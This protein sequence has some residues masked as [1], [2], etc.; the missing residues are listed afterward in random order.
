[1]GRGERIWV[2][3]GTGL[4]GSAIVRRLQREPDVTVL[5]RPRQELDLFDSEAV[6]SF[7]EENRPDT[8]ILAAAK[9]GGIGANMAQPV[10]FLT[11]NLAIQNNVMTSAVAGGVSTIM[12][13]GS[14][15]IYPREC[16]QPMREQDYMTGALEPTNESYAVAKIAGMR[17]AQALHA[18]HGTRILLPLPCNVYGQGDHFDPQNSHVLSALVVKFETAC[19]TYQPSVTLWGTGSAFREFIHCDDLADAC[20]FLLDLD[21]DMGLVNVGTGT[22]QSIAELAA[23]VAS[24]VGFTGTIGWDTTKPD[25]MPRKVLD[26]SRLTAEGWRPTVDLADGIDSVIAEYRSLFPEEGE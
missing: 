25:G 11:E 8:V 14:S 12:F 22:D 13:L 2:A 16:A 9:V 17:L 4:V 1:V 3:G 19:R 20:L 26:V 18:E 21:T 10:A 6:R 24:R 7:V 15:C 5:T 23:L